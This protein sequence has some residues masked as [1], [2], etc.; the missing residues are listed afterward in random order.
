MAKML[1]EVAVASLYS[2]LGLGTR[3]PRVSAAAKRQEVAMA[4][5]GSLEKVLSDSRRK[6]RETPAW[7]A[8]YFSAATTVELEIAAIKAKSNL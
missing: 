3:K 4:Q 7:A 1:Q 2:N 5:V 6:A 8:A